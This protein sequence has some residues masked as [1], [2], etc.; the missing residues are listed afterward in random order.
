MLLQILRVKRLAGQLATG[1]RDAH[2]DNVGC[3]NK[4]WLNK[5]VGRTTKI[6]ISGASLILVWT[7]DPHINPLFFTGSHLSSDVSSCTTFLLTIPV[8]GGL[9]RYLTPKGGSQGARMGAGC[10]LQTLSTFFY[11]RI[12]SSALAVPPCRPTCPL[13]LLDCCRQETFILC[14]RATVTGSSSPGC[15]PWLIRNSKV[16]NLLA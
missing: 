14:L 10:S 6:N 3:A 5:C 7:I 16:Y 2:T 12:S 11:P 15:L 8:L 13:P 9:D 1:P 4:R